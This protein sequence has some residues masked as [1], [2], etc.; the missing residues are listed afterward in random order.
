MNPAIKIIPGDT[1]ASQETADIIE[2]LIRY[3]EYRS[4]ASSVYEQTAEQAA[5]SS[6]G[7]FRILNDWED[8]DSFDQE[9]KVKRIRNPFSVYWDP[10]A[11]MP[12]REDADFVFITEQMKKDDFE[13]AYKGKSSEPAEHDAATDG[14]ENWRAGDKVVVAE[15]YWKEPSEHEIYQLADG[16]IVDALQVPEAYLRKRKVKT[17][18]IMWAKLSGGDVLEGPQEVPGKMLPVVAVTGEE[19]HVGDRVYRSSVIRYAKD[20]QQMYNY[21]RSAQTEIVAM[22]PI[23]PYIG[24]T[25]QFKG[26]TAFWNEANTSK[27]PYLPYNP[28]PKAPG[29]PQRQQPPVASSGMMSETMAAAEDMKATTGIYDAGLGQRSNEKS[30]VAIR[31]RQMESDISTSIYADNMAKAIAT[32]GRIIVGMIPHIYDTARV[33]RIVK[34]NDD[35]AQVPVN[36]VV[37]NAGVPMP[38]NDLTVGKYEVRV[39]VGPNYS[40]MRQETAEGM[41]DF[42]RTFPA[43]GAVTADLVAKSMDWPDADKFAERLAKV[44][45]PGVR[46]QDALTPEEQQAQQAQMMQQAQQAQF[47]QAMQQIEAMK[48]QAEAKEAQADAEKAGLEVQDQALELAVKSGQMNAAIAQLVQVEVARALQ[49][50]FA[51]T[52]RF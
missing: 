39:A 46:E 7:N 37:T 23:S 33:L 35:V 45:P 21:W 52:G 48:K 25:D 22:Q 1:K 6:I 11:E 24:T 38:V 41:L 28:D 16:R 13:K 12:T 43:A 17:H 30:G 44:L 9:I 3:I 42:I 40:T 51:Q 47:A 10:S 8:D 50:A 49:G 15:Y 32:A 27:R 20:A 18:K 5:A 31:Q 2:G 29:A 14:M 34:D 26:L 4:D 36:G 19:W